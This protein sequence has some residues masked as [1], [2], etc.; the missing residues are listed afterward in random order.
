MVYGVSVFRLSL[1]NICKCQLVKW[2]EIKWIKRKNTASSQP[3]AYVLTFTYVLC[4]SCCLGWAWT[5]L[6]SFYCSSV[7]SCCWNC[8]HFSLRQEKKNV[9][10][11]FIYLIWTN[12]HRD[13]FLFIFEKE[14]DMMCR[15]YKGWQT[16]C[17]RFELYPN[18]KI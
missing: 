7:V 8:L 5:I 9:F 16:H 3:T 12:T 6:N 4:T 2:N 18:N 13:Y 15:Q 1:Q 14:I 17:F 11:F 10:F